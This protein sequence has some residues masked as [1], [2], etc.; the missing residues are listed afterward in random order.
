MGIS[1]LTLELRTYFKVLKYGKVSVA[2]NT[3]L[4]KSRKIY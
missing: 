1:H 4:K 2:L 3:N